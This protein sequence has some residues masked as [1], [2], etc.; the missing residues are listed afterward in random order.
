MLN[1]SHIKRKR[2]FYKKISKAK[3]DHEKIKLSEAI[4]EER[5]LNYVVLDFLKNKRGKIID[6]IGK[7]YL[8]LKI[9]MG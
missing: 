4:S 9:R 2:N 5:L 8:K 1:N 7:F 3:Y 6:L